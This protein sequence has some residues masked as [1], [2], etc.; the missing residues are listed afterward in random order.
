MTEIGITFQRYMIQKQKEFPNASG[1]FSAILSTIMY[2]GKQIYNEVRKTGLTGIS[3]KT[4]RINIQGESVKE[5]D[6]LANEIFY[7]S[8][9]FTGLLCVMASEEVDNI[10][11]IPREFACGEYV[12][13]FDPLDGSSNIDVNVNIGSIFSVYRRI[14]KSGQGTKEDCLQIGR[15]QIAA[16]YILYGPSTMLVFSTGQGVD[17][18]TLD[19]NLG[20]FLLSHPNIKIPRQGKIYSVNESNS[21]HWTLGI[22]HYI[23]YLKEKDKK[24]NRPYSARYI[25]SLVADFHRNLLKGG[26]FLYPGDSK[27]PNGKLRLLYEANPLAFLIEQA[28]GKA[29]NGL[30]DILDIQPTEI[31]QRVP[32]IIGS[33]NDVEKFLEFHKPLRNVI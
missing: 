23:Q 3:Q 7:E 17:G 26:I 33:K 32:L 16:G 11:S 18:F 5:L 4:G 21:N 24:T 8:F 30:L 9:K 2:A 19:P 29:T 25:G 27:N 28:D 13:L 14:S 10:L 12:L 22:N 6:E 1:D 20:E 15:K 31:H